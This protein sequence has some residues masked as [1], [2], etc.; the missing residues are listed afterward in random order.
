MFR[1]KLDIARRKFFQGVGYF[2]YAAAT[3]SFAESHGFGNENYKMIPIASMVSPV[4]DCLYGFVNQFSQEGQLRNILT[5]AGTALVS[6]FI[7]RGIE[8]PIPMLLQAGIGNYIYLTVKWG[9]IYCFDENSQYE[10][11]KEE[12]SAREA[13]QIDFNRDQNG[14]VSEV[15]LNTS[16][17][18]MN[19]SSRMLSTALITRAVI[20]C[21]E[22]MLGFQG[23]RN[24][25]GVLIVVPVGMAWDSL[26]HLS[27]PQP[28]HELIPAYRYYDE[29]K[30]NLNGET[31]REVANSIYCWEVFINFMIRTIGSALGVGVTRLAF[32]CDLA[33]NGNEPHFF[34]MIFTILAIQEAVVG[35]GNT[36][37]ADQYKQYLFRA[38][39]DEEDVYDAEETARL[40]RAHGSLNAN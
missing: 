3:A 19:T 39:L 14:N 16:S 7:G 6:W 9:A 15:L 22:E 29:F 28:L 18:I 11:E 40:L 21:S 30:P 31:T 24:P 26:N 38:S 36:Y 23:F 8:R 17:R 4:R 33:F 25:Y 2:Y 34:S 10:F 20:Q 37:R 5:L 35:L 32:Q 1:D 12:K 27:V 13:A